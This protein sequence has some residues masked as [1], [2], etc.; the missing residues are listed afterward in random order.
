M[1]KMLQDHYH[2]I[3]V[4]ELNEAASCGYSVDIAATAILERLGLGADPLEEVY[5][6]NQ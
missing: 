2:N 6:A 3:V 1:P 5:L 4:E